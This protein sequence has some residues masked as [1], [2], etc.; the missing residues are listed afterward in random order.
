MRAQRPRAFQK[1]GDAHAE[2]ASRSSRRPAHGEWQKVRGLQAAEAPLTGVIGQDGLRGGSGDDD[3][4]LSPSQLGSPQQSEFRG[5]QAAASLFGR[6]VAALSGDHA[7]PG[8]R[9]KPAAPAPAVPVSQAAPARVYTKRDAARDLGAGRLLDQIGVAEQKG[10]QPSYD[11]TYGY[12]AFVPEGAK[13]LTDMTFAEVAALQGEM[14]Q[15]QAGAKLRSSA[16]GKYQFLDDEV[17]RLR[18]KL[19]LQ[20]ADLFTAGVQDMMARE[21]LAEKGYSDFLTGKI[22]GLTFQARIAPKWASIPVSS[23]GKSYYGQPVGV[24]TDEVQAVLAESKAEA[25]RRMVDL[26]ADPHGRRWR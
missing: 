17:E 10:R 7:P 3:L 1:A 25:Q 24:T 15:R 11:V 23:M 19:K 13:K 18:K 14:L 2:P 4:S 22:D 26:N 6:G 8:V 20:P 21:I 5:A 9:S 12:G 16:V